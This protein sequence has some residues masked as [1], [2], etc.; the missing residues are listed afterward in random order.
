MSEKPDDATVAW[1]ILGMGGV[2]R[3]AEKMAHAGGFPTGLTDRLLRCY[4]ARLQAIVERNP[5]PL[6]C[7]DIDVCEAEISRREKQGG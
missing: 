5:F 6:D 2:L 3:M 7:K 4:I 1:C